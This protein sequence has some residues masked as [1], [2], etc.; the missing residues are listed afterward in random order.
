MDVIH[1]DDLFID[2]G[3]RDATIHHTRVKLTRKEFELLWTLAIKPDHVFHRQ[4]LLAAVWGVN[5]TVEPRTVDAHIAHL[6]KILSEH[7]TISPRIE[8][9]WGIG[10]RLR[11]VS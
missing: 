10:Y 11:S 5:V 2:R 6:R 7:Q 4:E 8:T 3:T 9:V 1:L